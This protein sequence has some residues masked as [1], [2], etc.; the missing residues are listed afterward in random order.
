M[1]VRAV[2]AAAFIGIAAPALAEPEN[3]HWPNY[4]EGDFILTDYKFASGESLPQLKLHYRTLGTAQRNAAGEIVN[5]VLLLQGNTGT[6]ANWLRPT[7]AD[8]LFKD[9]Q[10]LDAGKYFII[11]PDALGRGGS[12]QP[13]DGLKASSRT[14]A[15]TTWSTACTGWSPRG[16]KSP[17]CALSSAARSAAC[18]VSCGPRLIPT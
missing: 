5:G 1:S 16:S 15:I 6:G 12:S 10:P 13:S 3:T 7:L 9:R 4:Q 17:I 18:T 11:I 14:I 8:E 2:L